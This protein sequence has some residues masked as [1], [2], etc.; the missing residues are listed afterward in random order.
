M[1]KEN[2]ADHVV[3]ELLSNVFE[4]ATSRSQWDVTD[5]GKR[6]AESVASI[7]NSK[8]MDLHDR[9]LLPLNLHSTVL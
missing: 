8:C 4:E 5:R 3:E 6:L 9:L 7:E 2:E 1:E